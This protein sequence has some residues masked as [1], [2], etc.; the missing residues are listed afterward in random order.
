MIWKRIWKSMLVKVIMMISN[1]KFKLLDSPTSANGDAV[2]TNNTREF[3]RVSG[4]V[5]EDWTLG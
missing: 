4:L 5:V 1:L 3:S 2:V